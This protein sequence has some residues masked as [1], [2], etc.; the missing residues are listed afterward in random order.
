MSYPTSYRKKVAGTP[1]GRG[2]QVGQQ[3]VG[4]AR[5]PHGPR[6]P[7]PAG[8]WERVPPS[9]PAL[10]ARTPLAPVPWSP[11]NPPV[12][13]RV[14]PRY[15]PPKPKG[16]PRFP[17]IPKF[18]LPRS[19]S[20]LFEI[21]PFGW[22]DPL[23]WVPRQPTD[24]YVL[25]SICNQIPNGFNGFIRGPRSNAGD[26]GGPCIS[27]Q[28]IGGGPAGGDAYQPD[29]GTA[30]TGLKVGGEPAGQ[31]W[32]TYWRQYPITNNVRHMLWFAFRKTLLGSANTIGSTPLQWHRPN[33]PAMPYATPDTPTFPWEV[34]VPHTR[35]DRGYEI[36]PAV[37]PWAD[38][39]YDPAQLPHPE[40]LP[41]VPPSYPGR[42]PSRLPRPSWRPA[43]PTPEPWPSAP[44]PNRGPNTQPDVIHDGVSVEVTPSKTYKPYH[45][46]QVHARPRSRP[47]GRE[48]HKKG[49]GTVH[50]ASTIGK[51]AN[52]VTEGADFIE[53][54]WYALPI[55]YRTRPS[56][57]K[58][59]HWSDSDQYWKNR[60]TWH[61]VSPYQMLQDILA[62]H[63]H[64]DM[65]K[66]LMNVARQ[67]LTDFAIGKTSQQLTKNLK[68]WYDAMGRPVGIQTGP[69]L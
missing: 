5:P 45:Y 28:S 41:Q 2:S 40:T 30:P 22:P 54:I 59:K 56:A 57:W 4:P 1:R 14:K 34:P 3:W 18:K 68:P 51:I 39:K 33:I 13:G 62:H 66:A 23:T 67:Q 37:D 10:P 24:N 6:G 25:Y 16:T 32:L 21:F 46:P 61:K 64:L 44:F 31:R 26:V 43:R 65:E 38:P 17:K 11:A 35:P 50:A 42:L 53:A 12:P 55:K 49:I 52:W 15:D 29:W 48:Q 63:E 7:V 60:H 27:G 19:P 58:K 47:T 69:A 20:P 9:R 8:P 36:Y